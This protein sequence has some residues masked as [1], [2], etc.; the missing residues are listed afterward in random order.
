MIDLQTPILIF[1]FFPLYNP[2]SLYTQTKNYWEK[3]KFS[4]LTIFTL[5]CQVRHAME[6]CSDGVDYVLLRTIIFKS[7]IRLPTPH[8]LNNPILHTKCEQICG[9]PRPKGM[10]RKPRRVESDT[11]NPSLD[12]LT[13]IIPRHRLGVHDGTVD[14]SREE[15]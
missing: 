3:W 4:L 6:S 14:N 11:G 5:N 8:F 7:S 2:S 13:Y 9:T 15:K 10:T 1:I 12:E